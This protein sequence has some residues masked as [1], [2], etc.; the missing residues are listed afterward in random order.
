MIKDNPQPVDRAGMD[1]LLAAAFSGDRQWLSSP[2]QP[3]A[4]A[5]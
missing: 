4:R 2:L 3:D 5:S 1:R